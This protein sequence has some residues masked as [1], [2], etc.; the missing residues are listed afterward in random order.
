M[1]GDVKLFDKYFRSETGSIAVPLAVSMTAL[2]GVG[3]LAI[4]YGMS[5]SLKAQ[6]QTAA[7]SAAVAGASEIA[8]AGADLKHITAVAKSF[9]DINMTDDS[10]ST[11]VSMPDK[12][13][14]SVALTK[15]F[16]PPFASL[17]SDGSIKLSATATATRVGGA[18]VCVLALD[19]SSEKAISMSKKSKLTA[20]DCGAYSNSIHSNGIE[21]TD[22]AVLSTTLTCSAGGYSGSSLNF[23]PQ[24]VSD[25]PPVADP[26][27]GRLAPPIGSCDHTD[28]VIE[29]Q[30]VTLDPGV[31]CGGL[32][33]KKHSV[34]TLRPGIYVI[35]D[36]KFLVDTNG[37]VQGENVGI[38]LTGDKSV[39][40][41]WSNGAV[42]LTAPKDGPMA[43]LLFFED[44][45]S[46]PDR[47]HQIKS[48]EAR[49]LLGVLYFP[50]GTLR[51]DAS[52][53]VADQSAYTSIVA[54]KL[55]L[56]VQPVLVLNTDYGATDI[57]VPGAL[58]GL[59]G[60]IVLSK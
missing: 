28:L 5:A 7:D 26:L 37:R 51:V 3:G 42:S 13:S 60:K 36:G 52:Q 56:D 55:E 25:C 21:A 18:K 22:S 41:F 20:V 46:P 58:S 59:S 38:Y 47:V 8:L 17:Y 44:R 2:V 6:M 32:A 29:A 16:D 12:S 1:D 34:V 24:P 30:T 50:R 14:V 39:I 48:D 57:P 19:E 4:D 53:K 31:Y 54:N 49:V 11:S 33:V 35:K 9:A 40:K 23:E 45:N 43:S 15:T 27:V 10:V